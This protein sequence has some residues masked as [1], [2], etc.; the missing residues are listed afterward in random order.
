MGLG[1]RAAIVAYLM[2]FD[3]N[4]KPIV[5]Q[6]VTLTPFNAATAGPTINLLEAQAQAGGCDLVAKTGSVR[7]IDAGFLFG[8]GTWQSSSM[9]V[10]P[11][12]DAQLRALVARAALP[13]LTF[14]CVPP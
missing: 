11:I 3:S 10:P 4:L 12:S 2:A 9:L 8:D 5:G 13:S 7:R 1:L 6:Q 14:T